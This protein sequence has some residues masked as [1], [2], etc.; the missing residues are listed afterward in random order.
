MDITG[1]LIALAKNINDDDAF[2]DFVKKMETSC[3]KIHGSYFYNVSEDD[4]YY[5][6]D[7]LSDVFDALEYVFSKKLEDRI[8]AY[9]LEKMFGNL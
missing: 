2:N 4:E 1:N 6:F 5:T 9:T 7:S 3:V 8:N